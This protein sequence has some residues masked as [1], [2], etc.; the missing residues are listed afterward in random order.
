MEGKKTPRCLLVQPAML[1][2]AEH[3]R[4]TE[5]GLMLDVLAKATTIIIKFAP[6]QLVPNRPGQEG[7]VMNW[8]TP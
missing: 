5:P 7:T 3:G 4:T 2:G 8:T 1:E 6:G